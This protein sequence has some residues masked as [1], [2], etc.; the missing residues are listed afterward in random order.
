MPRGY[1]ERHPK[2]VQERFWAKVDKTGD[3]WPW[4]GGTYRGGYGAF[5]VRAGETRHA[6]RVAWELAN[7]PIPSGFFV[8][9]HCD[10]RL[11][12]NPSHLFLGTVQDNASDCRS[13]NRNWVAYGDRCGK[14]KLTKEQVSEIRRLYATGRYQQ[15]DLAPMFD[16]DRTTIHRIVRQ[17]RWNHPTLVQELSELEAAR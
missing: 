10:N 15:K 8:C 11:C 13:K 17:K 5:G 4:M 9:H 16:V 7:G 12:V 6:H 1:F 2:P 14:A 3:C